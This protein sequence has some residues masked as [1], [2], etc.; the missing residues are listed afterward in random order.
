MNRRN[1]ITT[2]AI[3]S[4]SLMTNSCFNLDSSFHYKLGYQLFSIRDRMAI[5]PIDTLKELK[6][7][8]Y[9]DFEIYGYD[10]DKNKIYGFSPQEFK[11][12]L[13]DLDL[14]VSS[15]HYGFSDYFNKPDAV[16][17][18]F[19][20]KCIIAAKELN[21]KYI[22]WPWL[23]PSLRTIEN[24]KILAS[25]LNRIG[26]Q[27]NKSG[28]GFAYHN[29]GYEFEKHNGTSGY[30]IIL[31]ETDPE[32]V[33]LQLDMYWVMHSSDLK[34]KEIVEKQKGR[35]VMW[36]IKDMDKQTRDYT[37]LGN[38]SINYIEELPDPKKSGLDYFYIE[39][40]GNFAVDSMKSA[41]DSANYFKKHLR[42]KL[43]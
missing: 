23:D 11:M 39:Q 6:S 4:L 1:F 40:G 8:G 9:E 34:P 37:E 16:L 3:G 15:G 41:I 35:I 14:T 18:K 25:K 21:S 31:N 12:I 20:D 22:T 5:A 43:S 13:N 29:H 19:V 2:S 27:V 33:K 24:F 32:L 17:E 38:G 36:H 10:P 26:E 30:Q 42:S 7:V 28:L